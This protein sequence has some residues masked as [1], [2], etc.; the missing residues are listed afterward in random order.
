MNSSSKSINQLASMQ[1][2]YRIKGGFELNGKIEKIKH[3]FKLSDELL[4]TNYN[5]LS[6]GKK[7]L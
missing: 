6:G 3:G 2:E 7:Q 4:S 1:E 5:N